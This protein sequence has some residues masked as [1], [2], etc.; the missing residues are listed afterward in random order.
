MSEKLKLWFGAAAG[1]E[2][3]GT[4]LVERGCGVCVTKRLSAG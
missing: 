3:D 1:T 4:I 2:P